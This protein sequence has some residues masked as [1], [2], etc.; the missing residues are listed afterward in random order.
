MITA[1]EAGTLGKSIG[2]IIAKM[3]LHCIVMPAIRIKSIIS[4]GTCAEIEIP[5]FIHPA[6]IAE[7]K[8]MGYNASHMSGDYTW[9]SWWKY[10]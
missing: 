2:E 4:R 6:T 1:E 5:F 7:L 3:Q 8:R 10:I 9:I